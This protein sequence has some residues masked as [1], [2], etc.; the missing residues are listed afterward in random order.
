MKD[1]KIEFTKEQSEAL[2]MQIEMI[3]A[4]IHLIDLPYLK[5]LSKAF[6]EQAGTQDAMSILA[7]RYDFKRSELLS[8]Q[9]SAMKRLAAFIESLMK[10][11]ELNRQINRNKLAAGEIE[12]LFL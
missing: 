2:A 7:P 1:E 5:A 6:V 11:D 4:H 12:K 10:C 9:A 3:K 8:E